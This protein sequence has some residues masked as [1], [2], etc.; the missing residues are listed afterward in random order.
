[1]TKPREISE[2]DESPAFSSTAGH[3]QPVQ[4]L[5]CAAPAKYFVRG[6]RR[7]AASGRNPT[8]PSVRRALPR[9]P[10]RLRRQLFFRDVLQTY[11]KHIKYVHA[12]VKH[13]IYAHIKYVPG[14]ARPRTP[15]GR[16]GAAPKP[17]R[18]VRRTAPVPAH[19]FAA[20]AAKQRPFLLAELRPGGVPCISGLRLHCESVA[21]CSMQILCRSVQILR[22]LTVKPTWL[23]RETLSPHT[24]YEQDGH[25]QSPG[26]SLVGL[27]AL[28][29][30]IV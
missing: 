4:R 24:G 7:R 16:E 14:P 22:S 2:E 12:Y 11:V 27:D 8:S 23:V 13:I 6:G 20:E 28:S 30:S 1:M 25:H 5:R 19:R 15:Q 26:C 9:P 17:G 21:Q 3:C 29:K 10:A 18:L